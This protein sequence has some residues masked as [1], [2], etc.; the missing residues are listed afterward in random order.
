MELMKIIQE[1]PKFMYRTVRPVGMNN[2]H[3]IL[4]SS[5][6]TSPESSRSV[7]SC[8]ST[9]D[10]RRMRGAPEGSEAELAENGG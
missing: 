7:L 2:A 8:Q 6:C 4:D 9:E 3:C 1:E 5:S 10:G